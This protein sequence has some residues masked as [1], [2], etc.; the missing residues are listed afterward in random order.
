MWDQVKLQNSEL[1]LWEIGRIIGQMWRDLSDEE[2][3]VDNWI[4][5]RMQGYS[6]PPPSFIL[7]CLPFSCILFF[8]TSYPKSLLFSSSKTVAL[9]CKRIFSAWSPKNTCMCCSF[10]E[11]VIWIKLVKNLFSIIC[12]QF[13][14][15][16]WEQKQE[17]NYAEIIL[18]INA[19]L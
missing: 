14:T 11:L 17:K 10:S 8:L 18:A 16:T 9:K 12:F 4:W 6:P 5:I 7:P 19:F 15:T 2:K 1:K 3:Q 13:I